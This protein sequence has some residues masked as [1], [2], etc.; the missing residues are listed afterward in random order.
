MNMIVRIQKLFSV[1][2]WMVITQI[3]FIVL[4]LLRRFPKPQDTNLSN[5]IIYLTFDD[6][7]SQYTTY[8][9]KVLSRYHVKSTFFVSNRPKYLNVLPKITAAGHSIGNHTANHHYKTLYASESSFLSALGEM[10]KIILNATGV[11][12]TLFRFPGGSGSIAFHSPEEALATRLTALVQN[13]GYQYF[14]W[15]VDSRDAIDAKTPRSVYKNIISGI[16]GRTSTIILQHDIKPISIAV[17]E[18]VIVWG[19]KNGYTFLP[20]DANTPAVHHR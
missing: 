11:R 10:E 4:R 18:R 20:L 7:P 14:D 19:L 9:L 15:D 5:K 17:V 13:Q 3:Y 2:V 16:Q 1:A 8:L 6:G 12:T